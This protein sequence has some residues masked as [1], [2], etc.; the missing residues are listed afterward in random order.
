MNGASVGQRSRLAAARG[1]TRWSSF[2]LSAQ[3][4]A[5]EMD[6]TALANPTCVNSVEDVSGPVGS[7]PSFE[8][9]ECVIVSKL[10]LY[11]QS[12][13]FLISPTRL[14]WL[15]DPE[16]INLSNDGSQTNPS[17]QRVPPPNQSLHLTTPS[18]CGGTEREHFM[19]RAGVAGYPGKHRH[20]HGTGQSIT[21]LSLFNPIPPSSAIK[22]TRCS[23]S[24]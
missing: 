16:R 7:L 3:L 2:L 22:G 23:C 17:T 11:H 19:S 4:M 6:R 10:K 9:G 12:I 8:H 20:T 15:P 1:T 13:S 14:L 5:S 21:R 18:T 24:S